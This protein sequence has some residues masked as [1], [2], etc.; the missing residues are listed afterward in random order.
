MQPTND[1]FDEISAILKYMQDGRRRRFRTPLNY[2][3]LPSVYAHECDD[4][5]PPSPFP[6]ST[7]YRANDAS[8]ALYVAMRLEID[9]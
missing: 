4:P 1:H 9:I 6:V 2:G 3:Y 7:H 5:F 8:N